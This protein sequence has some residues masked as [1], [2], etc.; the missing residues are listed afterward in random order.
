MDNVILML[1]SNVLINLGFHG[2]CEVEFR[3]CR[4]VKINSETIINL[5]LP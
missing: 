3:A 4:V 1:H 2:D 5:A